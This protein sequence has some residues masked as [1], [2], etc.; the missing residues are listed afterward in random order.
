VADSFV[1]MVEFK[2]TGLDNIKVELK[3]V[4]DLQSK[5]AESQ[6]DYNVA[7]GDVVRKQTQYERLIA[8]GQ[9]RTRIRQIGELNRAQEKLNKAIEKERLIAKYGT[10]GGRV[11]Q[12]GGGMGH[13]AGNLAAGGLAMGVAG[14]QGTVPMARLQHQFQRLS[15]EMGNTLTPVVDRLSNALQKVANWAEKRPEWQ[16]NTMGYGLAGAA[17]LRFGGARVIGAGLRIGASAIAGAPQAI[18]RGVVNGLWPAA[19][20]IGNA[21]PTARAAA[22]GIGRIAWPIAAIAAA[23]SAFRT[24][25]NIDGADSL[26]NRLNKGDLSGT[27]GVAKGYQAKFSGLNDKD[28]KAAI[29]KELDLAN[30]LEKAGI[31]KMAGPNSGSMLGRMYDQVMYKNSSTDM[32]NQARERQAVLRDMMAG[33]SGITPNA[34]HRKNSFVGGQFQALGTGYEQAYQGLAQSGMN[35]AEAQAKSIQEMNE[36]MTQLVDAAN[37]I[38][39]QQGLEPLPR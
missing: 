3:S 22:S 28:R 18:G 19:N 24:K 1:K 31:D 36:K 23:G 30:K 4:S 2:A 14:L 17:A 20:A 10:I 37:E 7:L 25:A 29:Q 6:E 21:A 13:M 39:K 38:R 35:T 26:E 9:M 5:I 15:Y 11:A 33:G 8:S 27:E 16:Q 34:D 32:V 12:Y